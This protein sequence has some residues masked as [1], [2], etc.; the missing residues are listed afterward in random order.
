[1]MKKRQRG[2]VTV[3]VTA[4]LIPTIFLSA[5]LTD[6]ARIKMYSN[7][8]LMAADN[9]GEAVLTEYDDLLK[10]LYGLFAVSQDEAGKEAI[11]TLQKY[12]ETSFDPTEKTISFQHLQGTFLN[13]GTSYSGFM[14]YKAAELT[15]SEEPV[16]GANLANTSVLSTQIGDFMRYRIVQKLGEDTDWLVDAVEQTEDSEAETEAVK[17]KEDLDDQLD[18]ALE[19]MQDYYDQ[20]TKMN[21]YKEKYLKDLNKN[22]QNAKTEINNLVKSQRYQDYIEAAKAADED[23]EEE[24]NTEEENKE[25]KNTIDLKKEGK[26]FSEQF[27]TV[28]EKYNDCYNNGN[29][30]DDYEV[31]FNNYESMASALVVKAVTVK[32]ELDKIQELQDKLDEKLANEDVSDELRQNMKDETDDLYKLFDSSNTSMSGSNYV[33]LAKLFTGN[34]NISCNTDFGTEA[35][36]ISYCLDDAKSYYLRYYNKEQDQYSENYKVKYVTDIKIS[37][38][39]DFKNYSG[40]LQL[41][42]TLQQTFSSSDESDAEK[43]AKESK[44]K[45]ENKEKEK[46]DQLAEEDDAE[47]TTCI[48]DSI[49]IGDNGQAKTLKFGNMIKSAASLMKVSLVDAKNELLLKVYTVSYDTGMF[50]SRVTNIKDGETETSLTGYEMS[51]KINYLYQAELEYLYGGHK[52]SQENLKEA[53]KTIL[54]FRAAVNLASTY[55][56]KKINDAIKVATEACSAINPVLGIAAAAALRL[57]I[58]SIET[59]EDWQLLKKGE[60]VILFKTRTKHLSAYEEIQ[61]LIPFGQDDGA[62]DSSK[63]AIS[64]NYEQYMLVL[65]IAFTPREDIASRTGDLICLNVNNV[66]QG[67]TGS[68]STLEFQLDKAVTAV[69]ASSS[70]HLNYVV[71]P[72]G[73]AQSTVGDDT[74]SEMQEFEKNRYKFTVI[75]GY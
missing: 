28:I 30:H 46:E 13:Q 52:S 38:F 19:A 34:K 23:T 54:I 74:Y 63:K 9:Y 50:S 20:L 53:R 14:P 5:F 59:Y 64:L 1:M 21:N 37:N 33:A 57:G 39:D 17:A 58:A 48:P 2:S 66:R 16:D 15:F 73:F 69:E 32:D 26:Y 68:I 62:E 24:D 40:Y 7:Q 27:D 18:V 56:I 67:S 65:L 42:T 51:Q 29:S 72:D 75:R 4:I 25:E 35:T 22:Y 45:G 36:N 44:K 60:S 11:E 31:A 8:A 10:E 70:V 12:M 55:K 47:N 71:M 61:Q 3:F 6:L 49:N 43:K 41:Y